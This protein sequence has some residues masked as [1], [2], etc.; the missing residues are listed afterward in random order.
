MK[1][2]NVYRTTGDYGQYK[3]IAFRC[4]SYE[5]AIAALDHVYDEYCDVPVSVLVKKRSN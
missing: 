5:T 2:Y 4:D 1:V 3:E